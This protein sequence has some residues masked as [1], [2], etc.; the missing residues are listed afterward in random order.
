MESIITS[1]I[2]ITYNSYIGE[3][4]KHACFTPITHFER[5][6]LVDGKEIYR[7]R[8]KPTQYLRDKSILSQLKAWS[9]ESLTS[10]ETYNGQNIVCNGHYRGCFFCKLWFK[11]F[12]KRFKFKT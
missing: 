8:Q 11:F 7:D 12:R 2:E 1:K 3:Y 9:H 10:Q 4:K 5:I 6:V